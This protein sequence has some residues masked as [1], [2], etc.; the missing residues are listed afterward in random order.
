M[1]PIVHLWL[2]E[3]LQHRLCDQILQLEVKVVLEFQ[4]TLRMHGELYYW[5]VC[6]F[7]CSCLVFDLMNWDLICIHWHSDLS[8]CK[9]GRLLRLCLMKLV[10]VWVGLALV[11][12]GSYFAVVFCHYKSVQVCCFCLS[13]DLDCLIFVDY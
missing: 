13:G 10:Y 1:D 9:C 4:N 2:M 8:C 6:F 12:F 7:D 11:C 3:R 5:V